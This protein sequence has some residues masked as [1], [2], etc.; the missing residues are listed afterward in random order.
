[1]PGSPPETDTFRRALGALPTGVTVVTAVGESGR[2][3]AT[4]N[5]VSS[6]SLDP[7]LMLA[8]LDRGSRTLRSLEQS[9]QFGVNVLRADAE[10]LARQFSTKDPEE[11]KW[12]GVDASERMGIPVLDSAV[13]WIGCILQDVLTGGDH[14]IVTGQVIDLLEREGDPLVFHRGSY[15]PLSR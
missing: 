11:A 7:M 14:V 6:L 5:A 2:S 1:M 4:A 12:E 3:G 15:R 8:C 10:D 9:G 13:L